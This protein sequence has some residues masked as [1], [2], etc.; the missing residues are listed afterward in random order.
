MA[1]KCVECEHVFEEGQQDRWSESRGEFWG[2]SCSETVSGCPVCHGAYEKAEVCKICGSAHFEEFIH[3]GVCDECIDK[4]RFN[5]EVLYKI[6]KNDTDSVEI[7]C[8]L[9]TIFTP[10][11]IDEILKREM[12]T[13]AKYGFVNGNEFIDRDVDWFG[14]MLDKEVN[15]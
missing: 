6:G 4:Y 9:S 1:Y 8:F 3:G 12:E 15:E 11:E 2:V 10:K 5:P 7:N 14:E 13:I